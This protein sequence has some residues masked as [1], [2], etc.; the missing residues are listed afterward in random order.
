MTAKERAYAKDWL[1]DGVAP[2][3]F[4][5]TAYCVA[6]PADL[7]AVIVT[8]PDNPAHNAGQIITGLQLLRRPLMGEWVT[9]VYGATRAGG[10]W[11]VLPY[12]GAR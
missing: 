3:H 9:L 4:H 5:R 10:Q 11:Y 1:P 8:P 12:M 2:R 7:C 6:R